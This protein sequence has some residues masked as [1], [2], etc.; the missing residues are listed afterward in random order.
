MF[1]EL[2]TI[3]QIALGINISLKQNGYLRDLFLGASEKNKDILDRIEKK[4]IDTEKL[5]EII[6]HKTNVI[7]KKFEFVTIKEE[8]NNFKK[9]EAEQQ[10]KFI[11]NLVKKN[12]IAI[13]NTIYFILTIIIWGSLENNNLLLID[14]YNIKT[15]INILWLSYMIFISIL[16]VCILIPKNKYSWYVIILLL[17]ISISISFCYFSTYYFYNNTW[18]IFYYKLILIL[19]SFLPYIF[20]LLIINNNRRKA[21]ST[22]KKIETKI[23]LLFEKAK[24]EILEIFLK[25]IKK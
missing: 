10:D 17:L 8:S 14:N 22:L 13:N 24:D 2:L 9:T 6:N 5:H 4:I 16:N 21:K 7:D 18:H 12:K 25:Q 1:H 11:P 3:L 15:I 20:I 19:N 23:S